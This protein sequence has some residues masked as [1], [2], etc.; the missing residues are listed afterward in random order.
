MGAF[1]VEE[2]LEIDGSKK[3]WECWRGRCPGVQPEPV[4]VDSCG[5]DL[6]VCSILGRCMG[7]EKLVTLMVLPLDCPSY[8]ERFGMNGDDLVTVVV[9]DDTESSLDMDRAL[10]LALAAS[11]DWRGLGEPTLFDLLGDGIMPGAGVTSVGDTT[12]R[13]CKGNA[14]RTDDP[15]AEVGRSFC[16]R[17]ITCGCTAILGVEDEEVRFGVGGM[18]MVSCSS[19][20]FFLL[21]TIAGPALQG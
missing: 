5:G 3:P 18:V 7:R 14:G 19:S 12:H 11:S 20:V 13:L 1:R 15:S 4:L 9:L 21:V 8:S 16:L 17:P 10:G 2:A 6:T